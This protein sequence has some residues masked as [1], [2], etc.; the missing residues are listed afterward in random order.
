MAEAGGSKDNPFSFKTFVES[1][2]ETTSPKTKK[3][4]GKQKSRDSAVN[5]RNKDNFKDE[6]PFPEVDKEGMTS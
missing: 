6:A 4:Q 1:K 2:Q 3:A 5:P